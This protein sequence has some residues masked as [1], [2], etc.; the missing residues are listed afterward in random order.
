[1]ARQYIKVESLIVQ[2]KTNKWSFSD[3]SETLDEI[4]RN[5]QMNTFIGKEIE[6]G[7]QILDA[8]ELEHKEKKIDVKLIGENESRPFKSAWILAMMAF[9]AYYMS[10]FGVDSGFVIF[11]FTI[12]SLGSFV[13]YRDRKITNKYREVEPKA[14]YTIQLWHFFLKKINVEIIKAKIVNKLVDFKLNN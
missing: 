13:I 14:G 1:M 10:S 9:F 4:T 11:L 6:E 3:E 2:S 8:E 5:I 7:K 12:S